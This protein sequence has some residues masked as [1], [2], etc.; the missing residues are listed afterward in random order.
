MPED[1]YDDT[2]YNQ[3][4]WTINSEASTDPDGIEI[5]NVRSQNVS[6]WNLIVKD[7]A[8]DKGIVVIQASIT[9]TTDPNVIRKADSSM[10]LTFKNAA[11][12]PYAET[13]DPVD[14]V[15][16]FSMNLNGEDKIAYLP[17]GSYYLTIDM[18]PAGWVKKHYS[19]FECLNIGQDPNNKTFIV[20]GLGQ[21]FIQVAI[22]DRA[23]KDDW[24]EFQLFVESSVS[25]K[26]VLSTNT[27]KIVCA[28]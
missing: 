15:K 4:Q 18:D 1:F 12:D 5:Q 9:S 10:N 14:A 21:P 11:T 3:I 24:L 13:S 8:L 23:F 25:G 19:Y 17:H 6:S 16:S 26:R 28:P 27:L 7:N 20:I 2:K 22:D